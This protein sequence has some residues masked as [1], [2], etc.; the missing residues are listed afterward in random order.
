MQSVIVFL[1]SNFTLTFF[2]LGLIVAAIAIV[3][4]TNPISKAVIIDLILSYFILFNIGVSFIYNFIMH[5]FFGE[6]VARFIDWPQS[7][8]QAEVG[9]ASLGFAVVGLMAFWHREINLSRAA[10]I[11]PTIFLWGAALN[12]LYELYTSDNFAPG[13]IGVVFWTDIFLPAI[14]L[15]LLYLHAKYSKSS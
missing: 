12:H 14:G 5:V 15:F 2:I 4:R 7:P 1:I 9:F 13:N 3:F 11:G 8:F 6:L 10:I